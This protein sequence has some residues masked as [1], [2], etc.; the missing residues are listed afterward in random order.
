MTSEEPAKPEAPKN[1]LKHLVNVSVALR[2]IQLIIEEHE[3]RKSVL[4]KRIEK[5]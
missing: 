3:E 5:I 4:M 1:K 2:V